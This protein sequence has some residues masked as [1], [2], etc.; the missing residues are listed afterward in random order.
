MGTWSLSWMRLVSCFPRGPADPA[1]R[2]LWLRKGE[3]AVLCGIP[4]V[5]RVRFSIL[6]LVY[7][8][9][10]A[11]SVLTPNALPMFQRTSRSWT[12]R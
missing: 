9:L 4:V 7:R 1:E 5:V 11:V 10:R 3:T 8:N 6:R 2:D 12:I